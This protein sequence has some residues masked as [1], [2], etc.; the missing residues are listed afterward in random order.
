MKD[1]KRAVLAAIDDNWRQF[2]DS[3]DRLVSED[4]SVTGALENMS[5]ND[6][7][8]HV[9]TWES[10]LVNSLDR[11]TI[12]NIDDIHRFNQQ[13]TFRKKGNAPRQTIE[14]MD[15][16]HRSLRDQLTKAPSTYFEPLDPFRKLIDSC[17]VLHYQEHGAQIRIWAAKNSHAPTN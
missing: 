3:L 16:V 15:N 5:V 11:R 17:T 9:T 4:M 13:E 14:E 12:E 8:G 7:V 6:I 10:E 1:R 2:R